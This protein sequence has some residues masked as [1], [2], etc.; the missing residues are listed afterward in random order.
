MLCINSMVQKNVQDNL[1]LI[2]NESPVEIL[3]T[4]FQINFLLYLNDTLS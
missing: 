1:Q 4:V 3:S 2:K